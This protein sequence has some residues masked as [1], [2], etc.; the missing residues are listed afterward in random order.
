MVAGLHPPSRY[1]G[2]KFFLT[3]EVSQV[4]G[5]LLID[6]DIVVLLFGHAAEVFEPVAVYVLVYIL[7]VIQ[8]FEFAVLLLVRQVFAPVV[9][10]VDEFIRGLWPQFELHLRFVDL[11]VAL[12][13]N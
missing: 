1:L 3:H 9:D 11:E 10:R 2:F 13:L 4:N 12:I 6:I 8:L 7:E 5:P